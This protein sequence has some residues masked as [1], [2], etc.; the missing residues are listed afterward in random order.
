MNNEGY[1][2][3]SEMH[4]KRKQQKKQLYKKWWFWVLIIFTIYILFSFIK[5]F[6]NNDEKLFLK[7]D[8]S[9]ATLS[10]K[11]EAK[12]YFHTN[13]GNKYS[14]TD[15]DSDTKMGTSKA[16]S[17]DEELTLYYAGKYRLTVYLNGVKKSKTLV[18]KP[19]T[20]T[21]KELAKGMKK[22]NSSTTNANDN[23]TKDTTP[24]VPTEYSNA[25]VQAKEY[26]DMMYMSRQDIYD[27]LSS[28]DGGKFP[29]EAAQYAVDNLNADYNKNA[30]ESAKT[31]QK[32]MNMSI[33]DI[34]QQLSS[35]DGGKFTQEQADYAI[36]HLNN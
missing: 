26:S 24:K 14:V 25:L 15:L 35:P 17:G 31:Y 7:V 20:L 18:V 1:H 27:Q 8:N 19:L 22:N 5:S 23:N 34:R 36:D 32:E 33:E 3:R 16:S 10:K 28:P 12:F 2:S 13:K 9:T 11:I 30:L 4:R 29:A 6:N 21:D